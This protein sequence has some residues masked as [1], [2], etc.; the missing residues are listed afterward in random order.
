MRTIFQ[1][2]ALFMGWTAYAIL[3]AEV[4]PEV[5]P[6]ELDRKIKQLGDEDFQV[7]EAASVQLKVWAEHVGPALEAAAKSTD[8]E[9]SKRIRYLLPY[10]QGRKTER[11]WKRAMQKEWPEALAEGKLAGPLLGTLNPQAAV[12][13]EPPRQTEPAK[14]A[15]SAALDW[16]SMAQAI[17]GRW[18]S[19]KLG[20]ESP[21]DVECTA[22]AILSMISDGHSEKFGKFKPNVSRGLD[23]LKSCQR[24]DGAFLNP[25]C[26]EVDVL[27]HLLATIALSEAAGI[28]RKPDTIRTAQL[29][30]NFV[31]EQV[32][33]AK[34]GY[35]RETGSKAPDLLTTTFAI[36]ALKSAKVGQLKVEAE[37]FEKVITFL[38]TVD[39]PQEKTY[40]LVP[41]GKPS[42]EATIMGC[43]CRI[44][45]GAEW[46]KQRPYL[47]HALKV[48][49]VPSACREDSNGL[50]NYF[51]SWTVS[52]FRGEP[53]AAWHAGIMTGLRDA[54]NK[55]GSW[56][57]SGRW[58]GSGTCVGTAL[59]VL[60]LSVYRRWRPIQP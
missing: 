52:S 23:F 54:Q 42:A 1:A 2:L 22:L 10:V 56:S 27:T 35:G 17:D 24:T 20:A 6:E 41:N 21:A 51:G 46:E 30:V 58:H 18:D 15:T 34:A 36:L 53:W 31:V 3:A 26:D 9:V 60:S 19:L 13:V 49:K 39:H 4:P 11:L 5:K 45:S 48:L 29:A 47:E 32:P 16:L 7:R 8:P 57:P 38:D 25:G 59:N 14:D 33:A 37:V 50:I 43:M 55:D 40:S 28:G 44:M 12:G